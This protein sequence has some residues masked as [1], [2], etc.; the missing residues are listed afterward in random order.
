[1]DRRTLSRLKAF[2]FVDLDALPTFTGVYF[3]CLNDAVIYVGSS[4]NIRSRLK[5]H[6]KSADITRVTRW[7]GEH[8]VSRPDSVVVKCKACDT[9]DDARK[10]EDE[11]INAF[12][13]TLNWIESRENYIK[14]LEKKANVQF[15]S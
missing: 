3:I 4:K 11:C 14:H 6:H 12:V 13:P 15:L 2:P 5:A 1:M 8:K 10:L 7:A 9:I